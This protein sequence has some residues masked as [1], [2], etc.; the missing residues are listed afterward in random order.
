MSEPQHVGP[1][2]H[3][4]PR[5]LLLVLPG[6]ILYFLVGWLYLGSGLLIPF[7][8][9]IGMWAIWIGGLWGLVRVMRRSPV[10]TPAVAVLALVLWA[11]VVWLGDVF[12]GWTA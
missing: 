11:T 4:K 1:D 9:Y 7:P 8:W 5:K 2:G 6:V 10:W 3:R 12:L